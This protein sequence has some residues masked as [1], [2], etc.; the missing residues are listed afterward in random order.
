MANILLLA[1]F[2][3][4]PMQIVDG[5]SICWLLR[6]PGSTTIEG[7]P[8]DLL[9]LLP[10]TGEAGGVRTVD[11]Y[12]PLYGE[13][14]YFGRPRGV[15]NVL[16]SERAGVTLEQGLLLVIHTSKAGLRPSGGKV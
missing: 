2:E 7:Q 3:R 11:L 8:G 14:L 10:L 9:S 16:M 1:G 5:P 12:Y 15:S 4:V 13:T 6:G